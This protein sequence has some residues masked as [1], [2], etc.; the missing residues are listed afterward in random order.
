MAVSHNKV[1]TVIEEEGGRRLPKRTAGERSDTAAPIVP[2]P[3]ADASELNLTAGIWCSAPMLLF[4]Q[5]LS[6]IYFRGILGALG[7]KGTSQISAQLYLLSTLLLKLQARDRK[8]A[9]MNMADDEELGLSAGLNILS[10]CMALF[11]YS[12]KMCPE[13][14]SRLLQSVLSTRN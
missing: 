4:A 12:Y 3:E 1:W 6:E 2:L 14:H 5:L 7:Y 10:K 8:N 9:V 13:Q 11:D